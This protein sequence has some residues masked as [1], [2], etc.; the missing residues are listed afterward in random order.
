M[1]RK[2]RPDEGSVESLQRLSDDDYWG[3]ASKGFDFSEEWSSS[4]ENSKLSSLSLTMR[5]NDDLNQFDLLR[6]DGLNEIAENKSSSE[7]LWASHILTVE[8]EKQ[9][10]KLAK[11]FNPLEFHLKEK[12]ERKTLTAA[13]TIG[14]IVLGLDYNLKPFKAKE[15]KLELL[16]AAV[17]SHDGNAIL[18]V[19]IFLKNTLKKSI[20]QRELGNFPDAVNMYLSYLNEDHE[21][22]ELTNMMLLLNKPEDAAMLKYDAAIMTQAPD[23]KLKLLENCLNTHFQVG[24]VHRFLRESVLEHKTCIEDQLVLEDHR[25]SSEVN[26]DVT[27]KFF[28]EL[29]GKKELLDSSVMSNLIFCLLYFYNV[30]KIAF[31]SPS[32]IR[33]RYNLSQKQYTWCALRTLAATNKWAEIEELFLSKNWLRTVKM[34]SCIGFVR[35]LEILAKRGAPPEVMKKYISCLESQDSKLFYA[36][37]YK[38]HSVVIEILKKNRDR[39]GLIEYKAT[40]PPHSVD[41]CTATT[42]LNNE[43]VNWRN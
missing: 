7:E 6:C 10:Q 40:L 37:K 12:L 18:V 43:P 21:V 17:D 1:E 22:D 25:I 4:A 8:E 42:I 30:P 5:K 32:N 3:C 15:Q 39:L 33:S 11:S 14:N 28:E 23:R 24:S 38:C 27:A 19:V 29:T 26:D 34:R 9:A 36:K 2:K 13:Q 16:K 20:F 31:I 41:F 35:V